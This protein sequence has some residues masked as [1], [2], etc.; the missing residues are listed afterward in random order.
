M[1]EILFSAM[2]Q[3]IE[4]AAEKELEYLIAEREAKQLE[5]AYKAYIKN[6]EIEDA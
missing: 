1:E 4:R 3:A 6:K 2:T 5:A